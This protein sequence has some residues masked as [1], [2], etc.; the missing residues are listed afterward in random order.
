MANGWLFAEYRKKSV[1]GH[2]LQRVHYF[3]GRG[4]VKV[5]YS[6]CG[7]VA[8]NPLMY[9]ADSDTPRCGN[10]LQALAKRAKTQPANDLPSPEQIRENRRRLLGG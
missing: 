8:H 3:E 9:A 2:R 1:G 5:L 7:Q 10:C 6:V 4:P